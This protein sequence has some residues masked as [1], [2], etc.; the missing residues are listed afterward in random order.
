MTHAIHA[1][2]RVL[3]VAACLIA[4][5]GRLRGAEPIPKAAG[6][7]AEVAAIAD[8]L[9]A[10]AAG[11]PSVATVDS[12]HASGVAAAL[13]AAGF[14]DESKPADA[15][16]LYDVVAQAARC[17]RMH[18]EILRLYQPAAFDLFS[19]PK[20]A[21]AQKQLAV[22]LAWK[23][24]PR[25][26]P[27]AVVRGAPVPTIEWLETQAASPDPDLGKLR[28]LLPALGS[29]LRGENERQHADT[30]RGVIAALCDSAA[31]AADSAT[32]AA[33]LK[34]VGDAR[35]V[36]AGD[37]VLR[38][39]PAPDEE[40]RRAAA[41]AI[42]R[43][44]VA[45]KPGSP[46]AP[47][48][49]RT[50]AVAA[51][52]A[53]VRAEQSPAVLAK[54]AEAAEAWPA[55]REVGQA[56]MELFH[57][58]TDAEVRRSILFAVANTRWPDRQAM[59]RHA[60]ET[61]SGGVL[62]AA[63]DAASIHP[64]D[65]YRPAIRTLLA[66]QPQPLPQLIDAVG[67]VGDVDMMPHLL[68][69]LE[70]EKNPAVRMKIIL[71]I[72]CIPGEATAR[73]LTDL[74]AN[75]AEPLQADLLCRIAGRR[76]LPGASRFLGGLAEDATAPVAIR[77]QA[78]WALGNYADAEARDSLRRLSADPAK[79][80]PALAADRLIPEPLEQ[81]RLF[82]DL[83]R[84]RQGDRA[85]EAEVARRFFAATPANQVAVLRS[86]AQIK[87]DSPLIGAGLESHDFAV[88][89]SAV[90]AANA[91]QPSAYAAELA[92]IRQSPFIT[93]L[94]HSGLDIRQLPAGLNESVPA[95][96]ATPRST[97]PVPPSPVP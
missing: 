15:E 67:A 33:L 80:F 23:A 89:E 91:A 25:S 61:A 11:S 29:W 46:T 54:L 96:A 97:S 52:L 30:F 40:V 57:R 86:L 77:G 21:E 36:A 26:L 34:L 74:L 28:L 58:S 79:Y 24:W 3:L 95:A 42:G 12:L 9:A 69:W 13:A 48:A 37:W 45:G 64:D 1:I 81:A 22:G 75:V 84:L 16:V 92:A 88:L 50:N 60:L 56:M 10:R 70:Q 6:Q 76:N 62:G 63:L 35:A 39:L 17:R 4:G 82:I 47:E 68:G 8:L 38:M 72:N 2:R 18:P 14:L 5:V 49:M 83:A 55:S 51:W 19:S 78:I 53:R 41:I 73:T 66:E 32:A 7:S 27:D 71:A 44:A 85:A 43:I 65:S 94:L 20:A 31:V 87:L 90:Q 59:I 93:A